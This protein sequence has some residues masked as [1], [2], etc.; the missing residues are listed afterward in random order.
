M[1]NEL[2]WYISLILTILIW[3]TWLIFSRKQA[4]KLN[5]PFLENYFITLGA[6]IFNILV[7]VWYLL[8][9]WWV[10]IKISYLIGPFLAWIL[11]ALAWLFAFI[12]C[13]KIGVWK[14]MS[15]WAPSGMIVSFL[16][17]ILYYNEFSSNLLYAII[18]I[19]IIIIGVSTVIKSREEKDD[20]KIVISGALFAIAAATIW[21]GTYLIP[22][23]ELSTQVSPFMTLLPLSIWM[24]AWA[25]AIAWYKKAFSEC[26]WDILQQNYL[27]V[28]SG[29]AW[30]IWNFFAIIAVLNLW[31]WKA[32]PL[33][34]LCGVVNAL[35][36]IYFL[37]EMKEK[38]KIKIFF[39]WM[40]VSFAWAIRLSFL[41]I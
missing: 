21:W 31:M 8:Y 7:F 35:F 9:S 18:A 6:I 41:K 16:W 10:E 33:A 5:N 19:I 14:A 28:L 1:Q 27:I 2:L 26:S 29:F 12:A 25:S 34:E 3:W 4:S 20:K 15:I 22:I 37:K 38:R 23:K 32:Y 17:W 30:A 13:W 39:I 11:W 40:I 36:A 24:V